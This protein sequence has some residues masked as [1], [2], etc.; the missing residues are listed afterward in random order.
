MALNS[1]WKFRCLSTI[2]EAPSGLNCPTLS[3]RGRFSA[4]VLNADD[5]PPGQKQQAWCVYTTP[6]HAKPSICSSHCLSTRPA[7]Y[8]SRLVGQRFTDP[9]GGWLRAHTDACFPCARRSFAILYASGG[10]VPGSWAQV[11]GTGL[12]PVSRIWTS[13]DFHGLGNKLPTSLNGV[14][15]TVNNPPP[16]CTLS[17][18]GRS[19]FRCQPVSPERLRCS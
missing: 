19:V 4:Q 7:E 18:R 17:I 6:Q 13:T 16:R 11:K 15:V 12:S 10:L 1:P 5:L 8:G 14:T 2:C 9:S 3:G